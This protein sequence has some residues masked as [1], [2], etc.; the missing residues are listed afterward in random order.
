MTSNESVE[1]IVADMS[2][3]GGRLEFGGEYPLPP[4]FDVILLKTGK[5]TPVDLKWQ[6]GHSA[7]FEFAATPTVQDQLK[8]W[9]GV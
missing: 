9:F 1:C 2:A 4:R 3:T 7:G 8:T 5:R 6:R